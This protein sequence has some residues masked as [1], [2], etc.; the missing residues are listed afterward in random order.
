MYAAVMSEATIGPYSMS[1]APEDP[2][3]LLSRISGSRDKAALASLF[4][5]FAPRIKSMM[6]KLG[7]DPA[8]AE[9][10]VQET[11]LAVWRKAH[12][13]SPD[14]GAAATWIFTIARNL[15]I[16]HLRRQTN[17]PYTDVDDIEIASDDPSSSALAE[18]SQV[19][20]RV[21][22]ALQTLPPEQ[23][24]VVR[25]SF[26]QDI[27]HAEISERLG[28]PLGTVKSRLRL[29]YDRLRPILEDLQ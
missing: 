11:L 27:A 24:E 12:L 8:L 9:D 25:L 22:E 20:S 2:A 29:A 28:I 13:Y 4:H 5:M 26:I 17:R 16:D 21:T 15:R 6:L 1:K 3:V 23:Q 18:R 7:A 14:R 10:L 19:V